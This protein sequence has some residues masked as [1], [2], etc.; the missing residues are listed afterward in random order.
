MKNRILKLLAA[1]LVCLSLVTLGG[2]SIL[3]QFLGHEHE[4][5]YV[6]EKSATCTQSGEEAHYHCS[7]CGKDFADEAGNR[8]L[9]DLVIPALG[10]DGEHVDA[11]QATCTSGGN[12]EYY[13]CG[14]CHL[15]FADKACTKELEDDD[16]KTE[17]L[18]HEPDE[19]WHSDSAVHF[20]L[21][22][23]CNVRTDA[24]GHDYKDGVCTVCG[25]EQAE[26]DVIYGNKEDISSAD[27]SIHFLE[28]GTSST[29]DCVLIKT[30]N[31]E[32]L[33]DAGA[34]Q[35]S[36]TTIREYVDQ[37]CTDGVL[38]YVIATHADQDH[39]AAMVGTSNRGKYNGILYSYD[40]G[41]II[42]F[43]RSNKDLLTEAGNPTLY[44]RFLTAV[45]YAEENGAAS[46]TGLQCYNGTD[47]AQRTY[48]L[49]EERTVS[50]NILYNY[51]YDH[52]SA[53]ENNY[54]VCMLLTQELEGG[55]A[56]NYLF[57][58]DLEKDGEEYLVKNNE[59][60]EVELFKA[61]HHGSPTSSNDV[62]L[63][64]IRPKNIVACC[65]CGSDEYTDENANQFP[66]QAF[67]TRASKHT[68]N[69]FVPTIVSDNADGYESMNGDVVFYYDRAEWEEEGSLKLWCSNNT[70]KLKD[71]EWF[72]ANRY[73]GI[74][75][76]GE[77]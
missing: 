70:T 7:S 15:A 25:Y 24:R 21:C 23:N 74:K 28:L 34:I 58:G 12:I 53:D 5:S 57:T 14:R 1:S 38:E 48:Y 47:G 61:G 59:L 49:D 11:K 73:W 62:L 17:A 72:K 8:E 76:P 27:L 30:G 69:I 46:Y 16:Y 54:S 22:K 67:I 35:G 20:H 29:G 68:E 37:Y 43:D 45:D 66:S 65:C 13:V 51:Y 4:M 41:T 75:E 44:S 42:R 18:G 26:D 10:H 33:I 52:S 9:D 32:V 6:A 36:I 55:G 71:T 19:V 77:Q 2:C 64:V 50:M 63:D 56:N 40:I 3:E 39:I 31:T 60:P